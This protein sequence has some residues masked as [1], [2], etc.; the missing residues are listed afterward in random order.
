METAIKILT[1]IV[2]P[3]IIMFL[4]VLLIIAQVSI[5]VDRW[6]ES[7]ESDPVAFNYVATCK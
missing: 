5:A 2:L 6:Q 7:Q 1:E 4:V 3:K